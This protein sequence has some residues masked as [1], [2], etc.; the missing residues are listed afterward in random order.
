MLYKTCTSENIMD[1]FVKV[2]MLDSLHRLWPD[3]YSIL[4]TKRQ[5]ISKTEIMM[6]E[7]DFKF[8]FGIM[9]DKGHIPEKVF[10]DLGYPKDEVN[11]NI[12]ERNHGVQQEWMQRAKVITHEYQQELRRERIRKMNEEKEAKEKKKRDEIN[13]I[14]IDADIVHQK[15]IDMIHKNNRNSA[16]HPQVYS[17]ID[18]VSVSNATLSMFSRLYAPEMRTFIHVR[19]TREKNI[20]KSALQTLG[21]VKLPNK[22]KFEDAL[23]VVETAPHENLIAL[24]YSMRNKPILKQ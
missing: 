13:A 21:I 16:H 20:T 22:E 12:I 1:G 19:L 15:L 14:H 9:Q 17:H 5:N 7:R 6:I 2:G 4:R 3:L 11:G 18:E 10:D 8:L 23:R 24:A